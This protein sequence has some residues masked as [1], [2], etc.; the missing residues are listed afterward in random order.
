MSISRMRARL[1]AACIAAMLA[2]PSC[3]APVGDTLY[4]DLGGEPAITRF[5]TEVLAISVADPRIAKDFDNINLDWLRDHIV[6]Q[7]CELTGGPCRYTGRGMYASHKG[8]HLATFDFN[9]FTEDLQ[10]AMDHEGVP[11]W[12]Q[13]RLLAILAPMYRNIVTR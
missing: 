11:F 8:L 5:V 6:R 13:N 10:I 3:T 2:M 12:T 9:A 7:F 4:A 1:C